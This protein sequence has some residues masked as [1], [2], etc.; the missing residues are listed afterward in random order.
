MGRHVAPHYPYSEPTSLCSY[1]VLSREAANTNLIFFSLTQTWIYY[2]Q[3][4]QTNHYILHGAK[5]Y[6]MY[7]STSTKESSWP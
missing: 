4:E 7:K 2:T 5:S 1:R 6:N 3:G